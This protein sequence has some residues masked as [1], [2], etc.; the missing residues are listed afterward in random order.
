LYLGKDAATGKELRYSEVVRGTRKQAEKRE[1]EL[2]AKQDKRA[3]PDLRS[4]TVAEYL[5]W[6]LQVVQADVRPRTHYRYEQITRSHLIPALGQLR[7]SELDAA[8]IQEA[9]AYWLDKGSVRWPGRGLSAQSVV[10]NLR[11]LHVGLEYAVDHKKLAVNPAD[12]VKAPHVDKHR[13]VRPLD[14]EQA[15]ALLDALEGHEYQ[16]LFTLALLTGM[17]PGEYTA[18]RWKEDVDEKYGAVYVRQ[19]VWQKRRHEFIFGPAKSDG[20]ERRIKLTDLE[21]GALRWQR[22]R[23][24][25]QRRGAGTAWQ[26]TGLVFTEA[27]GSPLDQNRARRAFAA[28]L[29]SVGIEAHRVYDLRH[30][31]ATLMLAQGENPKVVQERLGHATVSL[32]L[33]TYSAVLPGIHDE[34]AE[35]LAARFRRSPAPALIRGREG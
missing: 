33:D 32:T 29:K 35:R 22:E 8:H 10:H 19:G 16:H 2:R 5:T 9:K 7:L 3:L 6:W 15:Q 13:K 23:Q 21:L 20:S 26:S 18:V 30:T 25:A 24:Q 1:R 14:E 12:R 4:G 28:L 31:M 11:V 17:R 27:D 34:A